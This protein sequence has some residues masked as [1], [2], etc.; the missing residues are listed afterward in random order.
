MIPHSILNELNIQN[1]DMFR[2]Q[3]SQSV[4]RDI[5]VFSNLNNTTLLCV[6]MPR[7]NKNFATIKDFIDNA[8]IKH[9]RAFWHQVA[10]EIEE[11]LK[12]NE[13]LYISTHINIRVICRY[14]YGYTGLIR[15]TKTTFL[16]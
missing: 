5:T 1:Y 16:R 10:L 8:T 12:S 9:Q 6:P 7:K 14:I 3:L 2:E 13:I 15:E 11:Q 4:N